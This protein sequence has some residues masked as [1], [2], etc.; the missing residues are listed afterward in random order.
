VEGTARIDKVVAHRRHFLGTVGEELAARL[1]ARNGFSEIRDLNRTSKNSPY[2]DFVA[3]RDGA[4]YAI[5]VKARNKFVWPRKSGDR[6][7]LNDRYKLGADCY[8]LAAIAEEEH[9]A[10]AAWLVIAMDRH[11]GPE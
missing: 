8:R 11:A 6:P 9:D 10:K 2:A 4:R 3:E 7:R 1:L 5:S